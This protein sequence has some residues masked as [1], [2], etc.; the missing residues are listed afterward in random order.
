M[1]PTWLCQQ[2]PITHR[3]SYFMSDILRL[4]MIFPFLLKRF[5]DVNM[6][7]IDVIQN[8]KERNS[9]QRNSQSISLI[10]QCWTSYAVLAK[11]VFTSTLKD[12]DYIR[13]DQL[14]KTF[15]DIVLKV[16]LYNNFYSLSNI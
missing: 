13:L 8:I 9:L 12:A 11:L 5:L 2:N 4:T 1:P 3:A 6:V 10:K 14:S 16:R 15:N 7:K